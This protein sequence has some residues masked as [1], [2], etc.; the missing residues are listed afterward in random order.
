MVTGS[1][2]I[3]NCS[4]SSGKFVSSSCQLEAQGAEEHN[5]GRNQAQV[6]DNPRNLQPGVRSILAHCRFVNSINRE[7]INTRWL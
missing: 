7:E 6:I 2:A 4:T 5:G 3:N 1:E